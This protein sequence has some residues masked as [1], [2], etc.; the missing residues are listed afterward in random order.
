MSAPEM[1]DLSGISFAGLQF[2]YGRVDESL[3]ASRMMLLHDGRVGF[4]RQPNEHR[5][6]VRLGRLALIDRAGVAT[7]VFDHV[8]R[9]D[10]RL[11]LEGW[12]GGDVARHYLREVEPLGVAE[13][14]AR[15]SPTAR[16]GLTPRGNLV[17]VR[18]GTGSIHRGWTRDIAPHDR[19]WDLCVDWYGSIADFEEDS[20][21]EYHIIQSGTQKWP[22]VQELFHAGSPFWHYDYVAFPD[23][24]LAWSWRGVNVAFERMRDFDLLL[25]QPSLD[26]ASHVIHD[27]TRR[28]E[29][30]SIRYTNFV[31]VM[32]PIFSR[33]ALRL[34]V[35]TFGLSRSGFGL[36][37]LWPKRLGE[38]EHRIAIIDETSV[39]HTRPQAQ[40][41]DMADA[42]EEGR[43]LTDAFRAAWRYD[44]LGRI[45][46]VG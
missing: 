43:R 9:R 46:S 21:A 8:E 6:E 27:I 44:E 45:R 14:V 34:C 24:D 28:V 26:P 3:Y 29:G 33:A 32:T 1:T 41:Y 17:I 38:P 42:I 39:A 30:S 15:A 11:Y 12:F 23:D 18:A 25:G 10:G 40:T 31:E 7:T 13:P 2:E 5:W 4:Y 22:G 36:D 16:H 19:N 20:D 35:P 37:H